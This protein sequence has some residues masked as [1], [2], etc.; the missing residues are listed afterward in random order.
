MRVKDSLGEFHG[1][2]QYVR[3][4]INRFGAEGKNFSALYRCMFS[5]R[6]NIFAESSDGFRIKEITY[7]ECADGIE[8]TS[9]ALSKRLARIPKGEIVGLY[10][11]NSVL[12]IQIF[13]SIL[14]CGYKPLLLNLRMDMRLIE[15]IIAQYNVAAVVS[16]GKKFSV[17]PFPQKR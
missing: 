2:K 3:S 14:R 6:K 12:W 7:G 1:I 5:E 16:D 17:V 9:A 10:M 11:E 13:W 4:K 8:R 15:K